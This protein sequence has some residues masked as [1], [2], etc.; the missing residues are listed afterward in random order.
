MGKFPFCLP[1]FAFVLYTLLKEL[2][3]DY[4]LLQNY[5]PSDIFIIN[6]SFERGSAGYRHKEACAE[7]QKSQNARQSNKTLS[8]KQT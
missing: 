2:I 1:A 7:K 4:N 6:F 8:V 3:K 5:S